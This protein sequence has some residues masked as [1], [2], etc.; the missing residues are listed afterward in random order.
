[1]RPSRR[2]KPTMRCEHFE[3]LRR[4]DGSAW[5]LGSGAMGTTYKATDTRLHCLVAL[6]IIRPELLSR[7]P[8]ARER[9]LREAR[10]A[11]SVHHPNVASVFHLGELPDGQCFYAMEFIEGETLAERVGRSGPLPILLALEIT[12]QVT[13]ALA[14]A[15]RLDLIH[16]DIKPANLMLT[17]AGI[18]ACGMFFP[19]RRG[20]LASD[21]AENVSLVKVID[22]GLAR[23]IKGSQQVR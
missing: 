5:Q 15:A 13:R 23:S 6:K 9:F 3:I 20:S 17:L 22:F 14:A 12:L 2:L 4:E 7:T 18:N 10:T 19:G 1:M 8:V 16:R 11:A 21:G